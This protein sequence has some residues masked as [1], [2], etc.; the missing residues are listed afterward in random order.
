[1]TGGDSEYL[2]HSIVNLCFMES[3]MAT[4]PAQW[5]FPPLQPILIFIHIYR[6]EISRV[7][8]IVFTSDRSRSANFILDTRGRPST[9][10]SMQN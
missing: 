5:V 9:F 4:F 7:S 6:T 1:M 3:P 8:A 10:H 2:Q